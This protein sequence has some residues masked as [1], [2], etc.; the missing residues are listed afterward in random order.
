MFSFFETIQIIL[1]V[2]LEYFIYLYDFLFLLQFQSISSYLFSFKLG[3]KEKDI[4]QALLQALLN[5]NKAFNNSSVMQS[6]VKFEELWNE[7]KNFW[8]NLH[9]G[10]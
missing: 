2:V 4:R 1:P 6:P 8:N 9:K 5:R 10:S 7:M 3:W